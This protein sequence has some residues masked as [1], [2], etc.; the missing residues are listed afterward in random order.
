MSEVKRITELSNELTYHR[1]L[2]NQGQQQSLFKDISVPEYI[3]L[4]IISRSINAQNDGTDRIYLKDIAEGLH[5][6]IPKTSKMIGNLR[7]KGL[8]SWLHDGNGSEGTYITITGS[9]I[10][11]ME[12]QEGFLKEYYGRVIERFGQENMVNM[13]QLMA[14]FEMI[15]DDELKGI[16]DD[17]NEI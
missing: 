10:R 7:D 16:G 17:T 4:H 5:L 14:Q 1:Y 3:A 13:L 2:L 11:L 8:V 12:K 6:T 9:G 15:M